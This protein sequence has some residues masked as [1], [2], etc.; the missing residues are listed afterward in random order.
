M[1]SILILVFLWVGAVLL[2]PSVIKYVAK[3][4]YGENISIIGLKVS[5]RL[6]IYASRI[7]FNDFVLP[8]LGARSGFVR[9][10][11]LSIKDYSDRILFFDL[12]TGPIEIFN[13][14]RFNSVSS[15]VSIEG[16]KTDR[17]IGLEFDLRGVEG[18]NKFSVHAITGFGSFNPNNKNLNDIEFSAESISNNSLEA[19]TVSKAT[20]KITQIDL[21]KP[22]YQSLSNFTLKL[23]KISMERKHLSLGQMIVWGDLTAKDQILNVQLKDFKLSDDLLVSVINFERIGEGSINDGAGI[24]KYT[25]NEINLNPSNKSRS[26]VSIDNINGSI[27]LVGS[28]KMK[29]TGSGGFES[30]DLASGSQLIADLSKSE[31]EF[32][33]T[34]NSLPPELLFKAN[35]V[36][37]ISMDQNVAIN[38][39]LSGKVPYQNIG[40]KL[41]ECSFT[42]FVLNYDFVSGGTSLIGSSICT[43]LA[44]S[45]VNLEHS[46]KTLDTESF[47]W[48]D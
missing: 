48:S 42:D 10:V 8:S 26:S 35:L 9:A 45:L 28:E 25:V 40:C 30:F 15:V 44:C 14:A 13:L 29:I 24:V 17:Q 2:G 43:G 33:M 23:E 39:D 27:N 18:A 37:N 12:S 38:G 47:L 3:K 32:D 41:S 46:V 20:T 16:F 4:H 34:L 5:P 6:Q 11:S 21:K 19:I 7:E 31:F 22:L 36:L 1:Y